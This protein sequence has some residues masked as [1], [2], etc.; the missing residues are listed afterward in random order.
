MGCQILDLWTNKNDKYLVINEEKRQLYQTKKSLCEFT[1]QIKSCYGDEYAPAVLADYLNLMC[2]SILIIWSFTRWH[3]LRC[4]CDQNVK[5]G[6]RICRTLST[7]MDCPSQNPDFS[8]KWLF[9]LCEEKR[10]SH[11]QYNWTE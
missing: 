5:V 3:I 10:C 1:I 7:Q 2:G 9:L 11:W 4:Y 8:L 6:L